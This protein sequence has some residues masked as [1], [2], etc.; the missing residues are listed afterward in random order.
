[1]IGMLVEFRETDACNTE[2]GVK[3]TGIVVNVE[4]KCGTAYVSFLDETGALHTE[5]STGHMTFTHKKRTN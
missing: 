3:V 5:W 2:T 1:M 4:F